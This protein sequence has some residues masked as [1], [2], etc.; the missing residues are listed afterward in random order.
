[1]DGIQQALSRLGWL[2]DPR[3][4]DDGRRRA[5]LQLPR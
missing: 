2:S 4:A 3:A 5:A 1:M